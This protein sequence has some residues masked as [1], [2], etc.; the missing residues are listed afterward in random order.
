MDIIRIFSCICVF[1]YHLGIMKGGY[2]AV[3]TFFYYEIRNILY[4]ILV[5][6]YIHSS[7]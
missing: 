1:A 7:I 2:L 5:E 6:D 3:C 4:L